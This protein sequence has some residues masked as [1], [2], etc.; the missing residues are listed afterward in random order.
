MYDY[1]WDF[2]LGSDISVAVIIV[3]AVIWIGASVGLSFI[4]ANMAKKK[5][6]SFAGFYCLSF[7]VSFVFAIIIAAMIQDK[8]P[9]PLYGYP[10]PPYGQPYPPPYGQPYAQPQPPVSVCPN[11][12]AGIPGTEPF[13]TKCGAR[14]K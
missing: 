7:F 4:P 3:F 9:R 1:N 2:Y 5:G 11:C 12:G 6:Y 8:N 13:C 10:Y 14:V